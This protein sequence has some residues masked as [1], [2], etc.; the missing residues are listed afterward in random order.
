MLEFAGSNDGGVTW[1]TY[2]FRYKP[3]REWDRMAPFLAPTLR[4]VRGHPPARPGRTQG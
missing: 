2:P 1:R 3:Q 4:P